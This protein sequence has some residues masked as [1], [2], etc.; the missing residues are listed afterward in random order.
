VSGIIRKPGPGWKQHASNAAVW[1]HVS[2][3]RLHLSGLLRMPDAAIIDSNRWPTSYVKNGY[4]R[5]AGGNVKRGMMMWAMAMLR[6][7]A[8][9]KRLAGLNHADRQI[10]DA[11]R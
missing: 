8:K 6:I 10:T 1:D 5:V 9:V 2:G 7:D 4:I 11:T 3:M